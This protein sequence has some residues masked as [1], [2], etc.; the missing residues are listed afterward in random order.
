MVSLYLLHNGKIGRIVT[1]PIAVTI[2]ISY[3][4]PTE[5]G[6]QRVF[7]GITVPELWFKLLHQCELNFSFFR[8][9]PCLRPALVDNA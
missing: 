3:G 4:N 6:I 7:D 5:S 8:M 2:S 1:R 9:K